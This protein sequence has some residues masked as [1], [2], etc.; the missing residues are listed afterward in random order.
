MVVTV[1]GVCAMPTSDTVVVKNF[2]N[3]LGVA[4]TNSILTCPNKPLDLNATITG[5]H[6]IYNY[7]WSVNSIPVANTPTLSYTSPSSG[8][9][10][11]VSV[12]V[13]DSCQYQTSDNDVIVVLPNTLSIAIVDSVSLCGN[14]PFTLSSTSSGGYPDYS[15]QWFLLPNATSI[16]NTS[17]L[18]STTPASEGNYAIQVVISDS[19]G[20][21]RSDIQ[22][23]NVLPPC[24][25]EIPNVITPNGDFANDYFKIKNIEYHPNTSVTIF[26]RWGLKVFES[27][28]YN[29]EWKG[30]GVSDGTF[31]YVIDV[32]QDKNI[33]DLLLYLRNNQTHSTKKPSSKITDGFFL[34][35]KEITN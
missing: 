21:Q 24:Q 6:A 13:M 22:I 3:D 32:P 7:T 11:V 19:C 27:S 4:I 29:N 34:I 1:N 31:F 30:E 15:Y 12:S 23:I 17:G 2:V 10:Y 26:D 18:S 8:G 14:T 20:Y 5:G 25:V 33:V 35:T 9:T 16:S 28:N